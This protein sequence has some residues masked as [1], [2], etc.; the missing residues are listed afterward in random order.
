MVSQVVEAVAAEV[1]KEAPL[2]RRAAAVQMVLA[3]K[4]C[5]K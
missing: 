2:H 5:M 3:R 4:E 1:G